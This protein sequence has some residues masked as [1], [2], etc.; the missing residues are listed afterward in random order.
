MFLETVLTFYLII[1]LKNIFVL[2]IYFSLRKS[3]FLIIQGPKFR[4]I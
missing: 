4:N 1:V 3:L 2:S